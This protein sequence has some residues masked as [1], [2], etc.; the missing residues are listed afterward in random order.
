LQIAKIIYENKLNFAY[1]VVIAAF[2]GEEQ[3]LYGSAYMA[4]QY[5]GQKVDIIAVLNADMIAY[6]APN[7]NAQLDFASRSTTPSLTRTLTNISNTY[8]TGLA[9]GST[10]ACCT[11]AAS[12]YD[13]GFPSASYCEK[14]GYTIDPQYHQVGDLVNRVG[15]D[16]S[17][18][19]LL[20]VQSMLAGLL[21]I[22][23]YQ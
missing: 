15:Y 5:Y 11:D 1:T 6:R 7:A 16:I 14:N 4:Q 19:Y 21:T 2:S 20:I 3:G 12:F 13:Y 8:V 23:E 22:A 10:T 9:I 18:Q 17:G